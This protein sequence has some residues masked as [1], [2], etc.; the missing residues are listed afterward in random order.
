VSGGFDLR[1]YLKVKYFLFHFIFL[2]F[3]AR[4]IFLYVVF[5]PFSQFEE[6]AKEFYGDAVYS[7]VLNNVSCFLDAIKKLEKEQVINELF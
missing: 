7:Q 1:K 4:Y 3:F 6:E 2:N 5:Y